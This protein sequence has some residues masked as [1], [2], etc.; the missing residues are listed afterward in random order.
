MGLGFI[1]N[2]S[3]NRLGLLLGFFPLSLLSLQL[4]VR[5]VGGN[6]TDSDFTAV[7]TS[8]IPFK[9]LFFRLSEFPHKLPVC[10]PGGI[11]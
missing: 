10:I 9:I 7:E 3:A 4:F 5:T 1:Y 6:M 11:D 8:P 2:N